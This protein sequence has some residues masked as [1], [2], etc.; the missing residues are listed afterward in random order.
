MARCCSVGRSQRKLNGNKIA[1][2]RKKL[3]NQIQD[4]D[5]IDLTF[6]TDLLQEYSRTYEMVMVLGEELSREGVLIEVEKGG[7]DNRHTE[8]VENPA[9]ATY[10]KATQRL[11][12]LA[13]K[14]STFVK[15]GKEDG[16][17][18]EDELAAFVRHRP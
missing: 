7:K 11:T 1:A 17:D 15:Q 9:F 5:G 3:E 14:I 12:D 6:A 8:K 10:Y 2:K 4:L 18:E 13:R 16:E